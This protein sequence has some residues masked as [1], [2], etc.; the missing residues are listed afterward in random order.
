MGS[1]IIKAISKKDVNKLA[2]STYTSALDIPV[3]M[4][5]SSEE[6]KPLSSVCEGKKAILIVN[7]AT[8][9]GLTA[10]NYKEMVQLMKDH[11]ASGL[12]IVGAPCNEFKE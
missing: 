7:V 1:M 6:A 3:K 5:N 11:E 10:L 2:K 12:Q 4:L 8:K 9:W